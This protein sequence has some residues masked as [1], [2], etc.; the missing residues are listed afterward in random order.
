MIG[1]AAGASA[2]AE[3]KKGQFADLIRDAI[4]SGQIVLVAE[5]RTTQETA[6]ATEVI[7]SAVGDYNSLRI[8][9]HRP[10]ITDISQAGAL[11]IDTVPAKSGI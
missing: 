3:H 8:K 11:V 1:T 7:K 2:G 9:K 6:I 5:A 10:G 4:L